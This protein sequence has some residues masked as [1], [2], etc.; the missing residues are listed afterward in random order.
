MGGFER[1]SNLVGNAEGFAE[2]NGALSDPICQRRP[3]QQFHYQI[4]RPYIVE[5]ANIGVIQGSNGRRFPFKVLAKPSGGDFHGYVAS[6]PR[7]GSPVYFTH[8][9]GS[10]KRLNAIRTKQLALL[11][12]ER[13]IDQL[14]SRGCGPCLDAAIFFMVCEQK[15]NFAM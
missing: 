12:Q 6:E 11:Q 10:Q 15:R 14:R 7:V 1:F 2:G 5:P 8:A 9:S 4:V 13:R 3:L